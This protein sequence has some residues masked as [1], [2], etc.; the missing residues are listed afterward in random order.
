M[1]IKQSMI[2]ANYDNVINVIEFKILKETK[3]V[4]R[5][6]RKGKR[7]SE[8]CSDIGRYAEITPAL[9]CISSNSQGVLQSTLQ[10]AEATGV[11]S[12]VAHYISNSRRESDASQVVQNSCFLFPRQHSCASAAH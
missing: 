12:C 2:N 1:A 7:G 9:L 5:T 3:N 8:T 6:D 10:S 11:C 4:V